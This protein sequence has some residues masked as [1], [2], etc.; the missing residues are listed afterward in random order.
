LNAGS[1]HNG[2]V[3]SD[4]F[5]SVNSLGFKQSGSSGFYLEIWMWVALA[6]LCVICLCVCGAFRPPKKKKKKK[7]SA[8][9]ATP[10]EP[11]KEE[12]QLLIPSLIP[13]ASS[14][15]MVAAPQYAPRYTPQY[16]QVAPVNVFPSGTATYAS[17]V[18]APYAT[19]TSAY[20]GYPGAAAYATVG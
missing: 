12:E 15:A 20:V 2:T 5:F 9:P 1:L 16:G 11:A 6:V 14:Y 18:P 13:V 19:G 17:A 4:P 7:K 8:P 3:G 10:V